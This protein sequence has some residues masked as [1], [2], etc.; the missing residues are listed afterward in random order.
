MFAANQKGLQASRKPPIP[1]LCR[2]SVCGSVETSWDWP[3]VKQ[4]SRGR[5]LQVALLQ[6]LGAEFV[7]IGLGGTNHLGSLSN[8][9]IH[10]WVVVF[11][12]GGTLRFVWC[13]GGSLRLQGVIFGKRA[14]RQ[15]RSPNFRQSVCCAR[16]PTPTLLL[17]EWPSIGLP[18]EGSMQ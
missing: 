7:G 17:K 15:V 10:W 14:A 11:R 4:R 13:V 18:A 3:I 12:G 16:R 9:K 8:I 1:G 6:L 2:Q 5:E